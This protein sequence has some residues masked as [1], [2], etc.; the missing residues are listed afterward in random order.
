[1]AG[2]WHIEGRS[3]RW[4]WDVSATGLKSSLCIRG[5]STYLVL[6]KKKK[7]K[8]MKGFPKGLLTQKASHL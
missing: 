7:K 2:Q 6:R 8:K 1:M 3:D 5:C 4:C